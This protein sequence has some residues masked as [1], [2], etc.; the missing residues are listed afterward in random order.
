MKKALKIILP[1]MLVPTI[2]V[3]LFNI[4]LT[5]PVRLGFAEKI[6]LNHVYGEKDIHVEITDEDDFAQLIFLCKGR[7]VNDGAVPSCGFGPELIFEGRGKTVAVYLGADSCGSMRLGREDKYF[8][9]ISEKNKLQLWE[10]MA[11]YDV[12]FPCI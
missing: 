6:T 2:G 1:I 12:T 9:G 7:A 10:I 4:F 11:K 3:A 8:Y 5:K